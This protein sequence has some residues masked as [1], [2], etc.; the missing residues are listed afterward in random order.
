VA[1][2]PASP[3][4]VAGT[5]VAAGPATM[6]DPR[7][8]QLQSFSSKL[9]LLGEAAVGKSSLAVRFCRSVAMLPR[10]FRPARAARARRALCCRRCRR[11]A[12]GTSPI[13]RNTLRCSGE[14]FEYQEPT[15]GGEKHCGFYARDECGDRGGATP[16]PPQQQQQQHAGNPASSASPACEYATANCSRLSDTDGAAG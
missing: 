11:R 3:P 14:F 9:V 12:H 6:G 16:P 15:I 4:R 7:L 1:K 13:P 5:I 2:F 10:R 8:A